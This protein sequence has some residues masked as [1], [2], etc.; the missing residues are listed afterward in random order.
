MNE[1]AIEP[2]K[3]TDKEGCIVC[4]GVPTPLFKRPIP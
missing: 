4:K 3:I 2:E 1:N